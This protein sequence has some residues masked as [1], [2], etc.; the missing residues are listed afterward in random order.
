MS[1]THR[2]LVELYQCVTATSVSPNYSLFL[3]KNMPFATGKKMM[4]NL[5]TQV[6]CCV[7][8]VSSTQEAVRLWH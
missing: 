4:S 6:S 7:L 3:H 8:N 2:L 5:R 1:A